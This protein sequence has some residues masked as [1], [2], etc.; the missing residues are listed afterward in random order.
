MFPLEFT[1]TPEASPRC[2][3]GGSLMK[4]GTESNASSGADVDCANADGLNSTNRPA[5]HRFMEASLLW[6]CCRG[7]PA[8]GAV[9]KQFGLQDN[10]ARRASRH[11]A[12][13]NGSMLMPRMTAMLLLLGFGIAA[14]HAD[15]AADFYKGKQ[16]NLIV[17]YGTGAGYDVY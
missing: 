16:V 12:E 13:E 7:N 3:S 8:S 14:A 10:R 17:G 9:Y 2:M 11:A 15:T 1:A 6:R 4:P 5:S